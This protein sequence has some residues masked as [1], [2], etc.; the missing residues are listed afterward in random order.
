MSRFRLSLLTLSLLLSLCN[1]TAN[2]QE[3]LREPQE[4]AALPVP[5][6]GFSKP[7]AKPAGVPG[8]SLARR[9]AGEWALARGWRMAEAPKVSDEGDAVSRP[10]YSA[11]G[12]LEATVPGTALSTLVDRGVYPDP[13]YGLN[14][15]AIPE[16]LNRQDY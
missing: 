3:G 11:A 12:W 2:G 16:A 13:D 4:R 6:S 14:N 5:T 15:L 1:L 8:P 10:G 9:G 7:V